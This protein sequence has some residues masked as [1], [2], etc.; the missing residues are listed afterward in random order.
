[1]IAGAHDFNEPHADEWSQ[2]YAYDIVGLGA[3]YEFSKN[4]RKTN[5]DFFTWGREILAPADGTVVYSRNDVP[6]NPQPGE[7]DNKIFMG[8]PDPMRAVGGN[9]VVID[10][11]NGEFSFL[12][13]MQ[14]GSVRVKQGDHVKSGDIIG[15]LGNTGNS[16]GPHLHY[17]LMA[18][19]TVFRCDGLPSRFENIY[20]A[21][22][23]ER[24]KAPF[25][26][27]G[28]FLEAK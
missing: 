3:Q 18:C 15:L 6:E 1:M 8:R 25:A 19:E 9:N 16:D 7:I 2:H 21:F 22:S 20:D 11:G 28:L 10:H 13:H 5:A 4:G 26:K 27:R 24:L 12:A 17:H 23:G 14:Q